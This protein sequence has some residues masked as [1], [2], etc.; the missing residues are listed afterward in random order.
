MTEDYD[1]EKREFIRVSAEIPVKYRFIC[2][3]RQDE[4]L[5]KTYEGKT[6]NLSGGGLLL[7]GK[8][9]LLPWVP[10]MLMNKMKV[11]VRVE[12][13]DA[14]EPVEAV[15]RVAWIETLDEYTHH[16]HIG[17]NFKE[18]TKEDRDRIFQYVINSEAPE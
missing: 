2:K 10:E 12:L 3:H 5:E 7:E 4:E 8:I 16:S 1:H 13:P 9:P 15:S 18:I 6:R 11:A 17:L 14:D